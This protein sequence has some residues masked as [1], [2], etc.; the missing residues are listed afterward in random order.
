MS[1]SALLMECSGMEGVNGGLVTPQTREDMGL[2]C[3]IP[4]E[5]PAQSHLTVPQLR[6]VSGRELS[7]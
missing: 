7:E 3:Q 2:K 6:P 5:H 4:H 1:D